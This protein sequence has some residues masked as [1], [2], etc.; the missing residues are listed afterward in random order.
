MKLNHPRRFANIVAV[1]CSMLKRE[2][3][4]ERERE[5]RVS[6]SAH[7]YFPPTRCV[8]LC[9]DVAS[10]RETAHLIQEA[11]VCCETR[12]CVHV[13][14]CVLSVSIFM[15]FLNVSRFIFVSVFFPKLQYVSEPLQQLN[16]A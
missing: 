7:D 16:P 6:G 1:K 5:R 3:E 8:N 14:I 12:E 9:L 13:Y 4:R 10:A 2:T 11:A 15:F